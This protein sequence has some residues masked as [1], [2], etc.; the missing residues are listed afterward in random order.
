MSITADG[1]NGYGGLPDT[2]R[3]ALFVLSSKA[4]LYQKKIRELYDL[5]GSY[6]KALFLKEEELEEAGIRAEGEL[7]RALESAQEAMRNAPEQLEALGERGVRLVSRFDPDYPGRLKLIEDPPEYLYLR[8]RF[9]SEEKPSAGIIGA[10]QCSG[11]G[12]A[13]AVFFAKELALSGISI[14]SGMALGIDGAAARGA[15]S[16][17]GESFAV[18]GSGISVCYPKEHYALYEEM[19]CG[20]GGVISQFH[21][22]AEPLA[23][24]FVARNRII[25][26]LSDVLIVIEA[27]EKSGTFTTVDYALEQGKDV[28]ALPGRITDPLGRGCNRLLREGAIPLTRP[29][30]VTD[31]LRAE[32]RKPKNVMGEEDLAHLNA[33]QKAVLQSVGYDAVHVE[34]I[35]ENCRMTIGMVLGTLFEL[36]HCGYVTSSGNAYYRRVPR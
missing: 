30:D 28:F 18:L 21:P 4:K 31:Y 23:F 32:E 29:E 34:E 9:P 10:R 14:V 3:L 15:L 25:A 13:A 7:L 1:R 6:E 19:S 26:A 2:E 11:Y 5:A 12:N 17:G 33:A 8:G 27:R 22:G 20:K 16:A 35:A 36:E 24:H